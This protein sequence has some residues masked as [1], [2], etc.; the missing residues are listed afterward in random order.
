MDDVKDMA[1]EYH[2]YVVSSMGLGG[3]GAAALGGLLSRIFERICVLSW[4][5]KRDN[6]NDD[7]RKL[8]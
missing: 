8:I 4:Y 6:K 5:R 2:T 7:T 3:E 1:E